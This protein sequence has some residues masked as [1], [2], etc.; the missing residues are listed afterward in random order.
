M[1]DPFRVFDPIDP[2]GGALSAFLCSAAYFVVAASLAVFMSNQTVSAIEAVPT[3][4][5]V[6]AFV[7]GVMFA[8][9]HVAMSSTTYTKREL[10]VPLVGDRLGLYVCACALA[11][12][13]AT[14][15]VLVAISVASDAL[16]RRPMTWWPPTLV[17]ALT[18][19]L[20]DAHTVALVAFVASIA[21]A[22]SYLQYV[23]VES[24]NQKGLYASSL[25]A[26]LSAQSLPVAIAL[27]VKTL[28]LTSISF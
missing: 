8:S 21:S 24:V 25:G 28:V 14:M 18:P 22:T 23:P 4:H 6:S 17:D 3:F 20:L 13:G 16:A 2:S 7:V 12:F 9:I 11:S 26:C 1:N 15:A 10:Y 19:E 27:I 5:A